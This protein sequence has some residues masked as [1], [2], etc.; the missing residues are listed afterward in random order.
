[1]KTM[2]IIRHYFL[3]ED[4]NLK[5]KRSGA[6]GY[7]GLLADVFTTLGSSPKTDKQKLKDLIADLNKQGGRAFWDLEKVLDS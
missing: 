1:D 4:E 7:K 2:Q 5:K 3:V 6:F